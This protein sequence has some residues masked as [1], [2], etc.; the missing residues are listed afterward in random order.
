MMPNLS[1]KEQDLLIKALDQSQLND[2]QFLKML[3]VTNIGSYEAAYLLVFLLSLER[4]Q[5]MT[6]P[7]SKLA[8]LCRDYEAKAK[9]A[10]LLSLLTREGNGRVKGLFDRYVGDTVGKVEKP[11]KNLKRRR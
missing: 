1:F 9:P 8:L 7:D 10:Q 2:P 3:K 4:P 6:P 5:I 11:L